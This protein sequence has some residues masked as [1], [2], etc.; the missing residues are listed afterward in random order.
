[1]RGEPSAE[2]SAHLRRLLRE[3]ESI[4]WHAKPDKAS[5]YAGHVLAGLVSMVFM[6]P[7]F[8][9]PTAIVTAGAVGLTLG[10]AAIGPALAGVLGLGLLAA[11]IVLWAAVRRQY[12]FA[13]YAVTDD[14]LVMTS[15]LIGRDAST[16]SLEDVRDVDVSVGAIG[17]LFGTGQLAFQVAGGSDSGAT[18]DHVEAPYVTLEEIE[19]T[20]A[21]RR[22]AETT[23]EARA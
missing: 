2:A 5:F 20:R 23:R 8:A 14:R 15:G 10:E 6:A 1:M 18:F 4:D 22:D 3:D 19:G 13:E 21:E 11:P 17:K 9:V 16:V 12:E 7:F